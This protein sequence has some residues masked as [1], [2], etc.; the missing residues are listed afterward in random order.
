MKR[1]TA[2][3][4]SISDR[5]RFVVARAGLRLLLSRY[6]NRAATEIELVRTA[7]GSIEAGWKAALVAAGPLTRV[8]YWTMELR[9]LSAR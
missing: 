4:S 1:G 2:T 7:A 3:G 9:P 5:R 8:R 6:L